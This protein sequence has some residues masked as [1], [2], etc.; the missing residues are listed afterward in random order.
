ML[1]GSQAWFCDVTTGVVLCVILSSKNP[2]GVFWTTDLGRSMNSGPFE[3]QMALTPSLMTHTSL[4]SLQVP[5][6]VLFSLHYQL[7][8]EA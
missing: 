2:D 7:L 1:L 3:E 6:G 8:L 4:S 5:N